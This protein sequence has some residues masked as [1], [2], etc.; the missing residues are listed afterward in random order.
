MQ[1]VNYLINVQNDKIPKEISAVFAP[2][3][4][5]PFL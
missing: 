3:A 1:W 5:P 2:K 4:I